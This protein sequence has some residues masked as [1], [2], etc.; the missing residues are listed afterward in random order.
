MLSFFCKRAHVHTCQQLHNQQR[1]F[2]L[3]YLNFFAN[4][5]DYKSSVSWHLMVRTVC[6]C[7]FVSSFINASVLPGGDCCR[8]QRLYDPTPRAG[9]VCRLCPMLPGPRLCGELCEGHMH[10]KK[11]H[12]QQVLHFQIGF[13]ITYFS[14][15]TWLS[16]IKPLKANLFS[17]KSQSQ[18]QNPFMAEKVVHVTLHYFPNMNQYM[19][20]YG[21]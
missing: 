10:T 9:W 18:S 14:F 5:Y 1:F 3:N 2:A 20:I 16:L 15:S 11:W 4:P 21:N 8:Y 6:M 19:Y 7:I 12:S 13:N 17:T